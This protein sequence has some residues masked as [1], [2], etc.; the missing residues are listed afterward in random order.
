MSLKLTN[1]LKAGVA[2]SALLALSGVAQAQQTPYMSAEW[3]QGACEAWNQ[4]PTLTDELAKSGWIDNDG[5]RGFKMIQIYRHDCDKSPH[6]ELRFQKQDGKAMCS[7][8][9]AVQSDKMDAGSDYVMYA[10]TKRWEEMGRGEYGPMK[11]MM[12]G[13]LAFDGPMW[14]AMKNMGPF[15]AFLLIAGKVPGDTGTCP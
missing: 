1:S 4:D 13:R 10:E 6:I 3:G 2:A 7:Y 14:E 8:G 12:F 5:G 9:G 11:A 15:K